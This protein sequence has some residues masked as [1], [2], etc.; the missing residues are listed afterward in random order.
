ME[1][2]KKKPKKKIN[3]INRVIEPWVIKCVAENGNCYVG[4]I[5]LL[6]KLVKEIKELNM[7]VQ[8]VACT[9]GLIIRK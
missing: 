5:S 9:S 8:V 1:E 3:P 7:Q 6:K 2:L 4:G